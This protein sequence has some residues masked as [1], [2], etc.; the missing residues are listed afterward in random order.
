M[1]VELAAVRDH[2]QMRIPI[3]E[4]EMERTEAEVTALTQS[5]NKR[6]GALKILI[7]SYCRGG[8]VSAVQITIAFHSLHFGQYH[9]SGMHLLSGQIPSPRVPLRYVLSHPF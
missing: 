8:F 9:V 4:Q 5:C 2:V 3:N 6:G 7:T 1:Q